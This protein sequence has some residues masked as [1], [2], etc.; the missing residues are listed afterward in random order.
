MFKFLIKVSF[1][2]D[3]VEKSFDLPSANFTASF[4][5]EK[6]RAFGANCKILNFVIKQ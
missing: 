2:S 3:I 5:T 6:R 1:G 4:A